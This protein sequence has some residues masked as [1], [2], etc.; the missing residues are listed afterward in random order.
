MASIPTMQDLQAQQQKHEQAAAKKEQ[1]G[2]I[3]DQIMEPAARERLF[4]NIILLFPI[5]SLC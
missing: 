4:I 1:K 5:T 2:L 3:L